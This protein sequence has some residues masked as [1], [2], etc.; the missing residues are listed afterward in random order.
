VGTLRDSDQANNIY[1]NTLKKDAVGKVLVHAGYSHI[2]EEG[3]SLFMPMGA[4][5]KSL[6]SGDV[7]TIDQVTMR[8]LNGGK[9]NPYYGF[10]KDNFVFDKSIIFVD[11]KGHPLIH[12]LHKVL[13]ISKFIIL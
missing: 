13:L 4:K 3:D 10:V 9:A 2:S 11:E 5:L 7:L 8:E 6:I 12:P 1:N